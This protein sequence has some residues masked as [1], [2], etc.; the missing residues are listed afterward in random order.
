MNGAVLQ[1]T[2]RRDWKSA[3][4]WTI[5]FV[6]FGWY[7][8]ILVPDMAGLQR[9][10]EIFEAL[11]GA[12]MSMFGFSDARVMATPEGFIGLYLLYFLVILSVYALLVGLNI[13]ANDEDSGAIDMLL[14]LPLPR[15]RLIAEKCIAYALMMTVI[16]LGGAVGMILGDLMNENMALNTVDVLVSNLAL[17]PSGL[18]VMAFALLLGAVLRRRSTAATLG[19]LFIAASFLGDNIARNVQ[20]EVAQAVRQLSYFSHAGVQD[21][22]FRG[23]ALGSVIVLLVAAVVLAAVS[24]AAYQRRDVRV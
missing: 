22:L 19:G 23:V 16:A 3:L 7:A 24:A 9:Y 10:I 8:V 18:V 5:G 21:V 11:P 14:S 2:L 4:M 15:W 12:M 17:V 1:E 20:H 6:I 13:T